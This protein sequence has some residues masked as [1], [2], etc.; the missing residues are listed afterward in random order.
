M[1]FNPRALDRTDSPHEL[2]PR[3]FDDNIRFRRELLVWVDEDEVNQQLLLDWC[4]K[5]VLFFASA[6][7]WTLDPKRHP[8]APLRP[9]I[10][11]PFQEEI[12]WTIEESFGNPYSTDELSEQ[13]GHD[14]SVF[15][16]RDMGAS[17]CALICVDRRFLLYDYQVF[18]FV[19]ANEKLVDNKSNPNSM[20]PKIDIIHSRLPTFMLEGVQRNKGQF[21]N[22][23]RMC[24]MDGCT[25]TGD[26]SRSGRPHGMVVDEFAAWPLNASTDFLAAS[27]GA[28]NCR[29]FISTPKGQGNGFHQIVT[30]G[31]IPCLKLHW[32]KHPWH[33]RGL[34]RSVGGEIDWQD[35]KFWEETKLSWLRRKYPL[36]ARRVTAKVEG[37]PLLKEVYPFF[38]D[39]K[40]RSPYYDHE[41][42]RAPFPWI[43][44]Q[45]LDLDFVGSGSPFYDHQRMETYIE[46]HCQVPFRQGELSWDTFTFEPQGFVD[47]E[48]GPLELWLNL[49][50]RLG[51]FSPP[52]KRYVIGVD[53]SA[54]TGAS[55]SCAAVWDYDTR[56]KVASYTVG[57]LRPERFAEAVYALHKWFHDAFVIAEG[58]GH[59]KDFHARIRELGCQKMH[60]MVNKKGERS[61][62]PGLFTEGEAKNSLLVEFGRALLDGEAVSRDRSS[63]KEALEF[64]LLADGKGVHVASLMSK[65]PGGAKK[66][67]G[68]KW[69]ADCLAW[70][71]MKG[72][73]N[74]DRNDI[75]D[76]NKHEPTPAEIW[77]D[78]QERRGR[79][80]WAG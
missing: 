11:M 65:N 67:H 12:F 18:V 54:G 7:C 27:A 80:K 1:L 3:E 4:R 79:R 2:V 50:H 20:F 72:R 75:L 53:V 42:V 23:S 30:K 74:V 39:G 37:D 34:Y 73:K 16:S 22:P 47:R 46:E 6:L 21:S 9:F 36:L 38:K 78:E 63:C 13:A 10:V 61:D 28:S 33:T 17:V 25:T 44:S 60:W 19:S 14:Q 58:Q 51:K 32:T 31:D 55:N 5:D 59:G 48:G 29:L 49:A 35:R 66:N 71:K 62:F 69:M 56:E 77:L 8:G 24:V 26:A 41:C 52:P 43:V 45:E 40:V 70:Y 57:N 15:K 64:Q 76:Q 68:D